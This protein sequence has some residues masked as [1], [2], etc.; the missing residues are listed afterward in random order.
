M[1]CD[2]EV[3]VV[4]ADNGNVVSRIRVPSRADMNCFDPTTKLVFNPNRA[5]STLTV[6]H[7]DSPSKFSV[8][9]KVPEGGAARTCA[10]DEKTHKV[11][12]FYY[13]GNPRQGGKLMASVLAR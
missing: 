8:V 5:D 12:V 9:E 6:I 7:E 2:T 11:Y 1:A 10:V 4:N 13:E 3:V